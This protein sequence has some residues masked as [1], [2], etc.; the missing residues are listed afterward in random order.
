MVT[1]LTVTK[2]TV[3][4]LTITKLTVTKLTVI[5]L[6]DLLYLCTVCLSRAGVPNTTDKMSPVHHVG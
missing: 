4:K 3:T 1:K 2:L 5:K 6:I